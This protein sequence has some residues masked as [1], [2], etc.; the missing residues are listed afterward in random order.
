MANLKWKGGMVS[1]DANNRLVTDTQINTWNNKANASHTHSTLA[2]NTANIITASQDDTPSVWGGKHTGAYMFTAKDLLVGQPSQYGIVL[3][4][5]SGSEV[6]QLFFQH[7]HGSVFRRQGNSTGWNGSIDN[8]TSKWVAFLDSSNYTSYAASKSHTHTEITNLSKHIVFDS[9]SPDANKLTFGNNTLTY[10]T[11]ESCGDMKAG[12]TYAL[13]N[14]TLYTKKLTISNGTMAE[15]TAEIYIDYTG[16]SLGKI[17]SSGVSNSIESTYSLYITANGIKY[18]YKN[19]T[20]SE[21]GTGT[22]DINLDDIYLN[23]NGGELSG[24]FTPVGTCEFGNYNLPLTK[25]YVMDIYS[26]SRIMSIDG[27]NYINMKDEEGNIVF[28]STMPS[29]KVAANAFFANLQEISIAAYSATG[30]YGDCKYTF[31]HKFGDVNSNISYI[32]NL[33]TNNAKD[34]T[35]SYSYNIISANSD[36]IIIGDNGTFGSSKS[37]TPI[38]ICGN[39]I[40]V[41]AVKYNFGLESRRWLNIYTQNLYANFIH[42]G[43]KFETFGDTGTALETISEYKI[44]SASDSAA[45]EIIGYDDITSD[46]TYLITFKSTISDSYQEYNF[47]EIC[48]DEITI[49]GDVNRNNSSYKS[50]LKVLVRGAVLAPY[51]S[52]LVYLGNSN[53]KWTYVYATNGTIQTSNELKKNILDTG[54][55][56]RYEELFMKLEPI[57]FKW[58]NDTADGDKHD[59]IHL[60]LGAQ[61]TKKHMDE[62]GLTAEEYALYCEDTITDDEGN[63]TKEYGINYGQ[64]HGLEVHMIQ[65]LKKENDELKERLAKLEELVNSL[66]K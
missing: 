4:L 51:L 18:E 65:K 38:N 61:T 10:V 56:N 19:S 44:E 13:T 25:L 24:Y 60:G 47:A 5:S 12:F 17:S 36:G 3:N 11:G 39:M 14:S 54:I 63:E 48:R 7:S 37:D 6:S 15:G 9:A 23:A 22:N 27:F 26:R 59:R 32:I 41:A 34:S 30:E 16:S 42:S 52:N 1:Q 29:S 55:D 57:A 35:K 33:S 46:H 53:Y 21:S 49:G 50:D 8:T 2:Q 31:Q 45:L 64:L 20:P 58:N 28:G 40:P 66:V 43:I 62:V